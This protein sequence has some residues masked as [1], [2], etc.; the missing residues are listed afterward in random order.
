MK[1]LAHSLREAFISIRRNA[2]MSLVAISTAAFCLVLLGAMLLLSANLHALAQEVEE[3]V[4]MT[5]YLE[6]EVDEVQASAL[7]E[8]LTTVAGV[9]EVTYVTKEDAL[10]RLSDRLGEQGAVLG[11]VG[12]AN[13]LPASLEVSLAWQEVAGE[14]VTLAMGI[15]GV[16]EVIY[17]QGLF[18]QLLQVTEFL[19]LTG[20]VLVSA[21][22]VAAA[23]LIGNAIR[24]TIFARRRE[25]VIMRLVG[26]TDGYIKGP[27]AIEGLLLGLVGAGLAALL[28]DYGYVWLVD[29]LRFTIPF[30]P[31]VPRDEVMATTHLVLLGVGAFMGFSGSLLGVRRF[32][33]D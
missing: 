11:A 14:I 5:I 20:Y 17:A 19:R 10:Q 32:L 4:E 31:L 15:P 23:F 9:R 28:V 3:Q 24:L 21:L 1:C 8:Q 12:E 25:I 18:E 30:L 29:N 26:A 22:L 33:H 7:A 13:P 16:E 2:V 27:F 6:D